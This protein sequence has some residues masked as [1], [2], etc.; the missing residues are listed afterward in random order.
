MS[1]YKIRPR[2]GTATQWATA[3]PILAEREI[4]Y[5]V[6]ATGFGTGPVRMKMGDGVTAWNNLPYADPE[7]ETGGDYLTKSDIVNNAVTDNSNKVASASVVKS[8]N[9]RLA[10]GCVKFQVTTDGKLQYSVYTE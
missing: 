8:I 3:N 4:G 2:S 9:D 5:E 6:P 7:Q 10:N 1:Y